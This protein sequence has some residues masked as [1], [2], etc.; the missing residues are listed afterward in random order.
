MN[1]VTI[2]F[3]VHHPEDNVAVV[4]TE[5]VKKGMTISGQNM[6]DGT[7]LKL[8]AQDD[9]PLGHKVALA[10]FKDGDTVIKYGEDMGK[11]V[12]SVIKG[13]HIHVHNTKTK[14]W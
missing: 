4:V 7:D 3:L 2:N 13:A 12:A 5:D 1:K 14:R 8:E 11:T 10:D 6:H 9:I